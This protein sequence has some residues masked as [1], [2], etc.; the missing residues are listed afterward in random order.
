MSSCIEGGTLAWMSPELLN[1]DNADSGK[2]PRRSTKESDCYALG[3]VVYEVLSGKVPFDEYG[4]YVALAKVLGGERPE[5]P[6]GDAGKLFTD[7]I[8]DLVERC[9][10][11]NPGDR[12]TAK[13]VLE[14]L[15]GSPSS[16]HP[17]S[18]DVDVDSEPHSDDESD[19]TPDDS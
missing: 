10:K 7:D 15:G 4:P 16:S 13:D 2:N 3:M 12:A 11:R 19:A 18:Q 14:C 6:K 5:R 8:W 9:W 17:T 1:P